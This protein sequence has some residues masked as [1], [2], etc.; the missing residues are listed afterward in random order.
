MKFYLESK[1]LIHHHLFQPYAIYL[2]E[3]KY[4]LQLFLKFHWLFLV[5]NNQ[6][7]IESTLFVLISYIP[8]SPLFCYCNLFPTI[9]MLLVW[10]KLS[11]Q[12]CYYIIWECKLSPNSILRKL[13][14]NYSIKCRPK[15]WTCSTVGSPS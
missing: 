12:H 15:R 9:L 10:Y 2:I 11:Y 14:I 3:I 5:Y 13:S 8:V 6:R 1:Y 4:L 7:T